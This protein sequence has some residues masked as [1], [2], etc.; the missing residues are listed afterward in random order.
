M[1]AQDR[2][3]CE[4]AVQLELLTREQ[5]AECMRTVQRDRGAQTI[6]AIATG[7][8]FLTP[9]QVETIFTHLQRVLERR[10]QVRAASVGQREAE[11]RAVRALRARAAQVV[12]PPGPSEPP[13][14]RNTDPTPT[15][16]WKHQKDEPGLAPSDP[17]LPAVTLQALESVGEPGASASLAPPH[18]EA[19]PR[20][21]EAPRRSAPTQ[22]EVRPGPG[23]SGP[24]A[25]GPSGTLV[26]PSDPQYAAHGGATPQLDAAHIARAEAAASLPLLSPGGSELAGEAAE[27][28]DVP[29]R[30][31]SPPRAAY[32]PARVSLP[33]PAASAFSTTPPAAFAAQARSGTPPRSS[34]HP[35][36]AAAPRTPT[37]PG[38]GR[39]P[40]VSLDPV[41]RSSTPPPARGSVAPPALQRASFVPPDPAAARASLAPPMLGYA[42]AEGSAA[43]ISL[44]PPARSDPS[45]LQAAAALRANAG[46]RFARPVP[47]GRDWR[48]PSHPPPPTAAFDLDAAMVQVAHADTLA[49]PANDSPGHRLRA[50]DVDAPRYLDAALR[51]AL[52]AGGSDLHVHSGAPLSVRI[53][54][55]LWPLTGEVS[56]TRAAAERVIA[57]VLDDYQREQLALEGEVRFAYDLPDVGRF[58]AHVYTQERGTDVVFRLHHPQ[59]PE[60]EKLGL[61]TALRC[62]REQPPGLC[63]CSGPPGSGKSTSLAALAHAF[64]NERALHVVTLEDPIEQLHDSGLGVFEQRE[65]GR[66]VASFS[67]GIELAQRQAADVIVVSDLSAPGALEACLRAARGH[68]WVLGGLRASSSA[69]ALSK[70]LGGD[71]TRAEALRLRLA[72][73]LRLLLHQRLLP[74]SRGAGRILALE[75]LVNTPQVAQL[76]R[77]DKL[78]QLPAVMAAGRSTGMLALDDALDELVRAGAVT[79]EAA[80]RAAHRRERFKAA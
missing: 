77:E 20:L 34:F 78:Q 14:V 9:D 38:S 76:I 61:S 25:L 35:P 47:S 29:P 26:G 75:S 71:A 24:P 27:A 52:E 40:F 17:A 50:P 49:L 16:P 30:S 11:A 22:L 31:G 12:Q 1:Q 6:G 67:E 33:P 63:V 62:L 69:Q 7:L 73:A 45:Q 55:K 51:M 46:R 36:P 42:G 57:E 13:R 15:T 80:R 32:P 18:P 28:Y 64:A 53:D 4:I 5:A 3:F 23:A 43:R 19:S 21:S 44:N 59:L 2:L 74:R 65:L 48:N 39:P 72:H 10:R 8:G 60:P 68:G 56:L 58:R 66:H 41:R 37:P 70:L 54:G 79:L